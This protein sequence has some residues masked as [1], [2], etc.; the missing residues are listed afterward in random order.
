MTVITYAGRR[1]VP[2]TLWLPDGPV[3]KWLDAGRV[4]IA[5][6]VAAR[7]GRTLSDVLTR[8]VPLRRAAS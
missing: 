4:R 3:H 2:V 6:A 5:A 8:R 1:L 7:E